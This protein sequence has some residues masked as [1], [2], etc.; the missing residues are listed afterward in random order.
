MMKRNLIGAF[1]AASTL[2][3]SSVAFSQDK[4]AYETGM[5]PADHI[6]VPDGDIQAS[7][8]LISDAN[9]WTEANETRAK[10]LV[11]KGAAVVGIDFKEY[12]KALEADDDECIYMISD[13]ESLSQQIQRTAGTGSYRLPIV[14]G[15]GK[16]G[17]LALAMIAQ[18]PVST[19]REAVAVDPKAGLP[20]EK[21]LCTPATK[22]KVD[23]ETVYGLTDGA[24]PAPVSVIF[25]PDADQKGRDHVNALVKLHS[26]IEVTDVTDKADEVLTQTLSDKVDA[27]GDSGNPLGLPITVLE[28]KPVMD[29]MAVIYSGDGGWRDLDE[30]VGSALQ[31][32][33]VPVI[34][35]DA[36]RYFWKEKDPKEV[37]GDLARIIDTYRKEW[38][39]KNV[40][41]I[42]YSFGADIIPA[43]YNLLPDRVKSSV[44]Q[45]SLLGLSNEV[46]FEISVQGWLGVAG[47]GKGG[48]T[49]DDIAKIDPK[50]VQCVY[51]T[52]EEDEDPCPG[53]KAKGVETIGIEGGHHF[54]EDYE[55]LAKRIVTSL[56]TRL[57]K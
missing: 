28:A 56:K 43:T 5:I 53:L 13:I 20:L 36:L 16:G 37:A 25:T 57:A 50:L 32:Q 49:V 39:V 4:P 10:A 55:A 41:L 2:L 46:D 3:S 51:G 15:I 38:K 31:K 29:T 1:I 11:E 22:D 44:A 40:V 48:K 23:G 45:L 6:M 52:E 8:F 17:T 35:V 47:E 24:L 21:I 42:G 9:G 18:S 26:D 19:V 33:G 34:G 14:T 27:A 7:I 54:D 12:L 30:E